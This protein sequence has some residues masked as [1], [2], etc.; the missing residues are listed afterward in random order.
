[1]TPDDMTQGGRAQKVYVILHET[2]AAS[3]A[4]DF[5]SV[6]SLGV[7]AYVNHTYCGGALIYDIVAVTM[8]VGWM[9]SKVMQ[10]NGVF[11][12]IT[13]AE[14]REWAR[15]ET[16]MQLDLASRAGGGKR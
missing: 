12:S 14:L 16:D 15:R 1:M 8:F 7:L 4:K 6:G 13:F 5:G 9:L 2:V 3:L 10:R 11:H